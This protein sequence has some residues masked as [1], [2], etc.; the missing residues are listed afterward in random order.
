MGIIN[1]TPD[2]FSDGGEFTTTETIAAQGRQMLSA[3]VDIIDIGGESSR[4]FAEPVTLHEELARVIPAIRILRGQ[5]TIPI[6][7]DT[8]KAEV[9]R[10]AIKAGADIINDISALRFDAEMLEVARTQAAPII[11]MHMQ[12]KPADMQINPAYNDIIEDTLDF[13][14]QRLQWLTANG[15]APEK[16]IVDPGIGFG[17]T[18]AHNL[19]ILNRLRD[20]QELGCPVL[21]GHSRKSFMSRLLGENI[22][23][24][25]ATAAI[26]A[27]CVSRGAA[28]I[29][30]HNVKKTKE[31]VRLTQAI[32]SA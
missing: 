13:F 4:P 23:R 29:R 25:C 9:A 11:I 8:T 28:V 12:G 5:S 15:I 19:T 21:V 31:A 32:Q 10:Q 14:R 3:G 27:L 2:S 22:D 17:K 30:V 20:Y 18:M 16:I 7:I 26:A 1:V 24:D 6:S